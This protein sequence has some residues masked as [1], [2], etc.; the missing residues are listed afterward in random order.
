MGEA[1][2]K[3]P[4][5]IT[6]ASGKGGVGKT[7]IAVNLA[8][9]L[10]DE[11]L[12]VCLLD[13]DF[14]LANV[15]V[16]LG[17]NTEHSL[18]DFIEGKNTWE[19]VT[20]SGPKSLKII[21]G[22]RALERPPQMKKNEKA[23]VLDAL[24]HLSGYD[25]LVIDAPAGISEPVL[26]FLQSAA[27]PILIITPEPTSL[28]DAFSVLKIFLK[29]RPTAQVFVLVN[30]VKSLEQAKKVIQRFGAAVNNYL[31]TSIRPL[32]Y[33]TEDPRVTE[34]VTR[35]V[36]FLHFY[37]ETPAS[38]CLRRIAA[39]LTSNL[40]KAA[41]PGDLETLF[42]TPGPQEAAKATSE[43]QPAV[44]QVQEEKNQRAEEEPPLDPAV[45]GD[46]VRLL[47]KEGHLSAS[48]VNYALKVQKKL[49]TPQLLLDIIKD[50][51]FVGDSQIK[52]TLLKNRTG[53]RLGSL[54]VELGYITDKQL[55]AALNK[56]REIQGRLRL[57]EVLVENKYI[58]EY[59]LT[60]VLSMHLGY[61]YV[62]LTPG[63]LDRILMEKN[64]KEVFAQHHFL[65]IAQEN[66]TITVAM[67]DPLNPSALAAVKKLYGT[68]I[69]ILITMERFIRNALDGYEH[70][71]QETAK[72]EKT[73]HTEI[74]ETVDRIINEAIIKQA[75]DI[76]FEPLKN[77]LRV[78]FRK[79]GSLIHHADLPKDIEPAVINRLKVMAQANVAE[80]RRHQDGRILLESTLIGG[81]VD[82]RVSFYVTLFGEKAVLRILTKKVELYKI[83][84]LGM[85]PKMLDRF[86]TDALDSPTGVVIITGPT[87]AGKTTSLYAAINYCN[88]VDTNIITAEDP[89][90]Y[91]IEGVSQCS[92]N[93]KIGITF[94]ETLKHILRQDPDIIVLGEIRDRFSA[95]SAIQAALTGH[96]VLTT[97]HTE[98]TIGGLLRLMNMNIETFLISSTVVCVVAQR[99]LKKI[100]P[101]CKE[102]YTPTPREL[103]RFKYQL[104]DVNRYQFQVG[105]GCDHCDYTG[106]SGRVGI[107]E[108]LVLNEY[109]KEAILNRKTSY[110]IRRISVETTGLVTLLED[111]LVK[112]AH[113][114]TSLQEVMRSLP[115]LEPPRPIDQIIRLVGDIK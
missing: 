66:G 112:A 36:P 55:S 18:V 44:V 4:V 35:Q 111:G 7:N 89:V 79:D 77:R 25:V 11:R 101:A 46:I 12:K 97:F 98:D 88:S 109:V 30:Q 69:V 3:A 75:S 39:N 100:C 94:E 16:L 6:V 84:D 103:N 21:P 76:H 61:P 27:I 113:G 43:I 49:E 104:S 87:G 106:Y 40:I 57:G 10:I 38:R 74:I 80:R 86:R 2:E 29:R 54:L 92:I 93:P 83:D 53:I 32:G 68:N 64:Q 23:R 82:L 95:E 56:Q 22:G 81:E 62:E 14:G 102:P 105:R 34:A 50:L 5:I 41:A 47:V 58:S 63:M 33:V 26:N 85:G 96:K 114:I 1:P 59:D 52:D 70:I 42:L 72:P 8:L 67:S 31:H 110:E 19:E 107:F 24:H 48:Q 90:E 51:G 115:V 9:A 71:V 99:L 78:R 20:V 37:P 65:P 60:Q 73:D 108:V 13:A 17:L 28:T 15:D 91:V 45:S